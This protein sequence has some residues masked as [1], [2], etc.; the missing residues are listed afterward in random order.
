MRSF[1]LLLRTRLSTGRTIVFTNAVTA[2]VR[3]EIAPVHTRR[4]ARPRATGQHAAARAAQGARSLQGLANGGAPRDGRCREGFGHLGVDHVVHYQLPR[5]AEVYVHRSG[6]TAR[7]GAC[8]LSIALIEPSDNKGYRRLC[9]ELEMPDGLPELTIESKRLPK[10][11]EALSLARQLDRTAHA[12]SKQ[13]HAKNERAKLREEMGLPSDS[14]DDDDGEDGGDE[15]AKRHA[16]RQK[17]QTERSKA[18]LKSCWRGWIGRRAARRC[19]SRRRI[20]V[21]GRKKT[22]ALLVFEGARHDAT[23]VTVVFASSQSNSASPSRLCR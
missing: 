19:T 23:G 20:R 2:L 8:G 15:V 13:T 11:R 22:R 5:S 14:E 7:G 1:F 3:H 9:F 12:A 17:E 10:I 18:Q 6:R 16:R 21:S 4:S